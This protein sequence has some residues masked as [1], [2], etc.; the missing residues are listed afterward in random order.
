MA[1]EMNYSRNKSNATYYKSKCVKMNEQLNK[2]S[3]DLKCYENLSCEQKEKVD[4]G[5][6]KTIETFKGQKYSDEIRQV[7]YKMLCGNASL[8]NCGDL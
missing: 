6:I 7:H 3:S 8:A 1:F 2:T 5:K 4:S